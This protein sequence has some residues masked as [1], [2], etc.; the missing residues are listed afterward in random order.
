[1][2]QYYTLEEAAKLLQMSADDLRE[3]ARKKQVRAFQDRGTWRFRQQDIQELARE[4]GIGSEPELKLG[5][6]GKAAAKR[7]A[8]SDLLPVDF[9]LEDSSSAIGREKLESP[10]K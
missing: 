5:E 3:L 6:G 4:R 1:M 2:Q 9:E 10:Q 8:D 7:P